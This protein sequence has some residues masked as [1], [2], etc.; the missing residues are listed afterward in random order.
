MDKTPA[1]YIEK[2]IGVSLGI[3]FGFFAY[4]SE[5]LAFISKPAFLDKIISIASTLFGFLLA[6]LTLIV[7]S[8][9]ETVKEM[10]RHGSYQRLLHFNKRIVLL[11]GLVCLTSL[12]LA[13]VNESPITQTVPLKYIINFSLFVWC[14]SDALIFVLIFYKLLLK[15][16][17]KPQD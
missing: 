2:Y 4:N 10:Q 13:F 5:A 15:E 17:T 6:I 12:F 11:S 14:V 3:L 8:N 1:Y 7:Q 9:S 16:T